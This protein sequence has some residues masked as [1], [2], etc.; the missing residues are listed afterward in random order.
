MN[1]TAFER[2]YNEAHARRLRFPGL[3]VSEVLRMGSIGHSF[4][5]QERSNVQDSL[6]VDYLTRYQTRDLSTFRPVLTAQCPPVHLSIPSAQNTTILSVFM[7]K[8]PSK[9]K[10]PRSGG[11]YRDQIPLAED[12]EVIQVRT[13]SLTGPNNT[14]T[15]SNEFSVNLPWTYGSS[16]APEESHEFSLDPDNGWFDEALEAEVADVMENILL[17]PKKRVRSQASVHISIYSLKL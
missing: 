14:A 6:S 9:K 2:T 16:W 3:Q 4:Q 7:T 11:I 8:R 10:K 1:L 15:N 13:A 5:V 17:P 12:F